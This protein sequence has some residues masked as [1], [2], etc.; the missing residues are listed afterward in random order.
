MPSDALVTTFEYST[1][2]IK[3]VYATLNIF[4][5][6]LSAKMVDALLQLPLSDE[7]EKH[8]V[9]YLKTTHESGAAELL[10]LYYLQRSRFIEA[11]RLNSRLKHSSL[12]DLDPGARDRAATRNAIVDCYHAVLPRV[13]RRLALE[14]EL[15]PKRS[16]LARREGE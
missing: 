3:R 10:V 1:S 11:I 9:E 15:A 6:L 13:Q 8:L 12:S 7:E 4:S 2:S 5:F 14:A 16:L